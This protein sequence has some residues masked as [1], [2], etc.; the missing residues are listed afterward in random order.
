MLHPC[1]GLALVFFLPLLHVI[2]TLRNLLSAPSPAT[3]SAVRDGQTRRTGSSVRSDSKQPGD[4]SDGPADDAGPD[5]SS[6][7]R[8]DGFRRRPH[9]GN[10]R[11]TT[12]RRTGFPSTPC[13]R[14]GG[15]SR[16]TIP[17]CWCCSLA[18]TCS[19]TSGGGAP[20]LRRGWGS[21]GGGKG[22]DGR[23]ADCGGDSKIYGGLAVFSSSAGL[24]RVGFR[25]VRRQVLL[26]ATLQHHDIASMSF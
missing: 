5:R 4:G 3:L 25:V 16:G 1:V 17:C 12:Q 26:F 13:R 23:R 15:D 8:P 24:R 21:G 11:C 19:S 10:K 2:F 9:G 20:G 7:S 6:A 22:D 14:T 18:T